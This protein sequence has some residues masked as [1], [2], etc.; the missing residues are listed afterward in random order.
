MLKN[1]TKVLLLGT[2]I[3]LFA[4]CD[5]KTEDYPFQFR[6][7]TENYKPLNYLENDTIKGLAPDL[8]KEICKELNIPCSVEVLP[9]DEGYGKIQAEDNAVLFSTVLNGTRKDMFKWAGPIASLDE[10]FFSASGSEV[11]LSSTE[12]A[13]KVA[14]VGVLRDYAIT[15][16]LIG[17]GFTNLVYCTD[18][19]DAFD[20]LLK[21]TIDLFPS[22]KITAEA[23]LKTLQKSI[24]SVE[25]QI[26]IR[27]DLLYFA[28]NKSIP[29]DVVA[30]FQREIDR[31]KEDGTVKSLT[32]KYMQTADFPGTLQVYTE[33][34]PPLTFRNSFGEITGFGSDIVYE[35]LRRN[36]LYYDIRLTFWSIGY[37]L[38][39]NNPNVCLFTMDRT[40]IRE[41]QF[42]W[43]GPIGTNTT[44]FFTKAGSGIT[45]GSL[46][47]ARKL[48]S[49]G[50]VSSWFST[51]YLQGLGFTNLVS[52]RDP[53]VMAKKLMNGE[54]SAFV[55]SDVTFPDILKEAGYLYSDVVPGF[56]LMA[57]DYYV[58]FSNS[59]PVTVVNQ[60]QSTLTSMKADGTYDAIFRKWLK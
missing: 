13:K 29:D 22:D 48:A 30:D 43:V 56:S 57:S 38:A 54:I 34:Y 33:Q 7:I 44:W 40:A 16:Y 26:V 36:Q 5:K 12:D 39:L 59:T 1:I 58:A 32:Q 6:F 45:I 10:L 55:C 8:L 21:G 18:N 31:L 28:F 23:A 20:Q 2:L 24:Y 17:E 25:S 35:I 51:Q 14:R 47:D 60:W 42:Q 4:K 49:V 53:G 9:W 52:D 15:Q 41:N 46:E 27:T 11:S 19:V 3:L 50:T 37:E